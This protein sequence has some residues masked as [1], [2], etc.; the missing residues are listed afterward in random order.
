MYITNIIMIGYLKDNEWL[1]FKEHV[2][3]APL[4]VRIA[5]LCPHADLSCQM[6]LIMSAFEEERSHCQ[7]SGPSAKKKLK[8][9]GPRY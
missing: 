3:T 4:D 5:N 2:Y 6:V 8:K 9:K 1:L 7:I